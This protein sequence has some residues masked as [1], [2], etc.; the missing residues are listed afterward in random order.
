MVMTPATNLVNADF[1]KLTCALLASGM[2]ILY[3]AT[4]SRIITNIKRPGNIPKFLYATCP[5]PW[6]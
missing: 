5:G 2:I 1:Y 6:R 4:Q 3:P